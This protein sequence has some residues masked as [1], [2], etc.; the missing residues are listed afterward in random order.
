M[1]WG[2]QRWKGGNQTSN[3]SFCT[4][5]FD[6]SSIW[7]WSLEQYYYLNKD[8]T[9]PAN[10][11]PALIDRPLGIKCNPVDEANVINE[12]KYKK[13]QSLH[14]HWPATEELVKATVWNQ[15]GKK[16][17]T[18][19]LQSATRKLLIPTKTGI[20]C[21]RRN[22]AST[23]SGAINNSTMT[24]AM[25]NMPDRTRGRITDR[26]VHCHR[27]MAYETWSGIVIVDV[28]CCSSLYFVLKKTRNDP[29]LIS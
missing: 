6:A 19:K 18:V 10:I 9:Y 29:T 25:A 21:L 11:D 15:V 27:R 1:L 20:F 26:S 8:R 17:I 4:F 13:C 12:K 23:G 7:F 2:E 24:N 16:Y 14:A 28:T 5:P 22:G 3:S